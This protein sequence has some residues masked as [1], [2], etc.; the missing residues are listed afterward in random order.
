MTEELFKK[1][2]AHS[3]IVA[4]GSGVLIQPS[5]NTYSYIL[6]AKHV[7]QDGDSIKSCQDINVEL[8][9]R[10]RIEI[11]ACVTHE[12]RDAA[13]LKTKTLV[14]S[15]IIRSIDT[16]KYEDKAIFSG[17]P[18]TRR[19]RAP[20]ERLHNYSGAVVSVDKD[21]F[22]L[23]LNGVPDVSQI[24]GSSGGGVYSVTDDEPYLIG[25][26]FKMEGNPAKEPN[27]RV[28]CMSLSVFDE[29]IQLNEGYG[30][31]YPDYLQCFS[32]VATHTFKFE[33][34]GL[35]QSVEYVRNKL[36][37]V[38]SAL[39]QKNIPPPSQLYEMY[40]ENYLIKGRPNQDLF[41]IKLWISFLEF[42]VICSLL[43]NL[44]EL[45]IQ[46]FN[47]QKKQR[48][49]LFSGSKEN[50]LHQLESIYS[51]D[52]RG[53]EKGGVIVVSTAMYNGR[54]GPSELKMEQVVGDISRAPT[55]GPKIDVG[56]NPFEDYTLVHMD[57]LHEK[58]VVQKE[59]EYAQYGEY[60]DL[61]SEAL[62]KKI[63][64]EY[65]AFITS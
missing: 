26:E 17:F 10:G 15:T 33:G 65:G 11:E 41:E 39:H 58:C 36:H 51:S 42:I 4:D 34:V 23:A 28:L 49:F 60:R 1:I 8:V 20:E 45:D 54:F 37:A 50:W 14:D 35:P 5:S 31:L 38:A 32:S 25:V 16:A 24:T 43:D 9:G 55:K 2:R 48:R 40:K 3:V 59:D 27:G 57:G 63:K 44:E 12:S 19:G 62:I 47:P 52:F 13:I 53:L 29:I 22:T 21:L 64:G 30:K 56:R 61:S 7:V 18:A 46:Y 6:T